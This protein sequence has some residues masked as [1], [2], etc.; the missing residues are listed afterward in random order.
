MTIALSPRCSLRLGKQHLDKEAG[1]AICVRDLA[2]GLCPGFVVC[3]KPSAACCASCLCILL[4]PWN[5]SHAIKPPLVPP[6]L[7][8]SRCCTPRRCSPPSAPAS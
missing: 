2:Y 5:R 7:S 3:L 6:C 8:P 1:Q 4:K